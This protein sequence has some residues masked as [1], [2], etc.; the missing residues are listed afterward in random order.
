MPRPS[1]NIY[2]KILDKILQTMNEIEK[3]ETGK[4]KSK[5]IIVWRNIR[6]DKIKKSAEITKTHKPEVQ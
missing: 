2:D 4:L 5:K 1:K 6:K 3:E